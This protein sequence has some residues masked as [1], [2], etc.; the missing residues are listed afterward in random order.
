V[1][2]IRVNTIASGATRTRIG[3]DA[4]ERHPEIVDAMAAPSVFGR[5]GEPRPWT[6]TRGL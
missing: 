3:D 4:F 1:D 5:I 2:G 6:R